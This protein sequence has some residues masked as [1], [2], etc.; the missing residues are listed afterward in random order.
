M[1]IVKPTLSSQSA[2]I[3]NVTQAQQESKRWAHILLY[4]ENKNLCHCNEKNMFIKQMGC[5][6]MSSSNINLNQVNIGNYFSNIMCK[7]IKI[8]E[9]CWQIYTDHVRTPRLYSM[10]WVHGSC[11]LGLIRTL[12]ARLWHIMLYISNQIYWCPFYILLQF[13]CI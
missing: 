4:T 1:L 11:Y 2:G 12:I 13:M 8:Y 3:Y 7:N 6:Q 9:H 5:F 10:V